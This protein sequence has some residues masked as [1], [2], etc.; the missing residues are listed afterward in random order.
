MGNQFI[1]K[2]LSVIHPYSLMRS[3]E[4]PATFYNDS[5]VPVTGMEL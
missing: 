2:Y 3:S 5:I 4:R 1:P